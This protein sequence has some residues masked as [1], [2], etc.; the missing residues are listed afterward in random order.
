MDNS[1]FYYV[2]SRRW[3]VVLV[4]LAGI[5]FAIVRWKRHPKVSALTVAGLVLFQFQSLTFSSLYYFLPQ[6][7][8]RG[9]TWR[10]I[11]NLSIVLDL[12]HDVFFS[13]AI[14]LLAAAVFSGRSPQA[15]GSQTERV[16]PI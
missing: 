14:A 11:D 2:F 3:P 13:G 4:V 15:A 8:K 5:V 12:C 9:W 6:L 10:S 7:A 16:T 1:F